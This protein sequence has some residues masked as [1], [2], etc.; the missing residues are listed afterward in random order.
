MK[1]RILHFIIG[2]W[3]GRSKSPPDWLVVAY[4]R[5]L[6]TDQEWEEIQADLLH[7]IMERLKEENDE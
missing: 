5:T 2:F 6:M 1:K 7:R 4:R 3:Y